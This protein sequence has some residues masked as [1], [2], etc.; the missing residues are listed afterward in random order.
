MSNKIIIVFF[1][2]A[3]I[4]NASQFNSYIIKYKG[5]EEKLNKIFTPYGIESKRAINE[6][7]NIGKSDNNKLLSAKQSDLL[8]NIS[9]YYIISVEDADKL[10]E[11]NEH[12]MKDDDYIGIS[13]NYIYSINN[14]NVIPDDSLYN[15]QWWIKAVNTESAWKTG[16]SGNGII[17]GLIDTGIDFNHPDLKQNIWVNNKEDIN[18]NGTFEPWHYTEERNGVSGDLNGID[19]DGNGI[20]DDVIGYD[21]VDQDFANFGDYSNPDPVPEDQGEHG[22]LVAGVMSAVRNNQIGIAGIAYNAK[23]LTAKAFDITGNAESDDIARAIVYAAVNGAKVL[24]FS[25]GERDESP[26]VHDAIKFAHSMG[27]VMVA[28]SGNNGWNQKHY[29]SDH[30]EVISVGGIDESGRRS[31]RANYGSMLD[32]SAPSV[33]ILTTDVNGSYKATGGTSLS[34]PAVSAAAALLLESNPEL[35]PFEINGILQSNATRLNNKT[36]DV[37]YGGGILNIGN[38]VKNSEATVL[39]IDNPKFE[40]S[41]NIDDTQSLVIEGSALSALFDAYSISIGAGIMPEQWLIESNKYY[42]QVKNSKLA[43][44]DISALEPG[45]YTLSLRLYQKNKNILERRIYLNLI[46]S[47]KPVNILS[48][49]VRN[50][51]YK[52]KRVLI[53]GAVTDRKCK[54]LIKYRKTDE[55]E[56][57]ITRQYD[58]NSEFHTLVFSDEIETETDYSAQAIFFSGSGDSSIKNFNFRKKDDIFPNTNF[59]QKSYSLP[60]TYLLNRVHDLYNTGKAYLAVNDLSSLFIGEAAIY[61]FDNNSFSLKDSSAEGWIAAGIGDSNGDGVPEIFG[62]SDGISTVKQGE[63]YGENPF[64]VELFRSKPDST[65]WAEKIYDLD[66]DG[67][68]ELIGSSYDFVKMNYY[69]VYKYIDGD[70]RVLCRAVLPGSLSNVAL[71]RGSAIDDFDSDGNLELVFANTRGN[72]FIYEFRNNGLHLEFVD[73]TNVASS[74]Q[75]IENPDI[76]GDGKPEILQ[77]FAGTYELFNQG[78]VGTPL[79]TVRIIKSE[80]QNSYNTDY[81]KENIYGV[82]IGASRQ[83]AFFRNGAATGDLNNDGKD[84]IIVSA[85]PDLYIWSHDEHTGEMLPFWHYPSTLS[86]TAVVYD[87]DGNGVNELGISTFSNTSF[88]EFDYTFKGPKSPRNFEGTAISQTSASFKWDYSED[89]E[90]YVIFLVDRNVNPPVAVEQAR[91]T[92]TEIIIHQLEANTFYEFILAVFNSQMQDKYSDFSDIVDIYTYPETVITDLQVLGAESVALNFSGRISSRNLSPHLFLAFDSESDVY[93]YSKS[94]QSANDTSIIVYFDKEFI[95]GE[96]SLKN[97]SFQDYYGNQ[98]K[99]S[100]TPFAYQTSEIQTEMYLISLEFI[101]QTLIRLKFSEPVDIESAE[102]KDKFIMKP[103]GNVLNAEVDKTDSHYVL[104]NLSQEI[105]RHGARGK[106]Y[107]ITALDIVSAA[108]NPITKGA[109]NTLGFVIAAEDLM[110]VYVYPNPIKMSESP[111]IFF[112][113]LTP[114]AKVTIITGDGAEIITL[115]ET[116]G[117]GG[118]EWDGRD[119]NGKLLPVGIY[120]FKVS[121]DNSENIR[122]FEEKGKF[123]IL[124]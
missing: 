88:F 30:P 36:W 67:I 76:D 12:L 82:R 119:R 28:S 13:P 96:Y 92:D 80:G 34:A 114:R 29:P 9:N 22:T 105:R 8:K 64:A 54:M 117:N 116:D 85:F 35:S 113:N 107:T 70:Y 62:T 56:E 6:F 81:W 110:D 115:E 97:Y 60:R 58:F 11:L 4:T 1:L 109:G 66:G 121:G 2:C 33:N 48:F 44:L 45:T 120:F 57:Y 50:A 47:S 65:F 39:K 7:V 87:F 102:V 25:F 74:I 90:E 5:S 108:G 26:I 42:S 10:T 14:D 84:E 3:V 79:W 40:Q 98:I 86:N 77:V 52:G 69:S 55:T 111:E 38:A 53:V 46:S 95:E 37:Q 31:G 18:G 124:P 51:Y 100:E 83:G 20:I 19:D 73:S 78:E 59:V 21:F 101:S 63:T 68:D 61:E 49:E 99:E 89:A 103:I 93:S 15:S 16:L 41:I 106:N 23:I 112:A 17:I 71:T 72:L 43:E 27:C 32:I 91:T 94:V 75:F 24:N 123:V 118:V 104:I 122:V